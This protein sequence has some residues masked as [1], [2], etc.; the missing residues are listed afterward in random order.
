M[1][2]AFR[3]VGSASSCPKFRKSCGGTTRPRHF[4]CTRSTAMCTSGRFWIRQNPPM[5]LVFGQLQRKSITPRFDWAA[6]SVCDTAREWQDAV[7]RKGIP[8]I[9]ARL[10]R[11]QDD[12]R[13]TAPVQSRQHRRSDPAR[14]AWPMRAVAVSAKRAMSS[15]SDDNGGRNGSGGR[16]SGPKNC[17]L[18]QSGDFSAQLRACNGCGACRADGPP[19]RMCPDLS[20]WPFGGSDAAGQG[21]PAT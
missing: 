4:S 12:F 16:R 18:W 6:R 19:Q 2:S 17:L 7:D 3:P 9:T 10:S 11:T 21:E 15:H 1:T 5:P 8:T 20:S 14:P 13:S